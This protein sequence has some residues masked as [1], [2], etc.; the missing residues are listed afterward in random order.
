MSS[1]DL[2]ALRHR[3]RSAFGQDYQ[4]EVMLKIADTT[5][6]VNLTDIAASL[7]LTTS[8]VQSTWK[9]LVA[10]DLLETTSR[11][12]RTK[13]YKRR[14]GSHAWKW[15]RELAGDLWVAD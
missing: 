2:T 4:L 5:G 7:D 10:V 11:A 3:S 15:A 8:Q 6:M 1:T 12:H 14:K 9:R 13:L